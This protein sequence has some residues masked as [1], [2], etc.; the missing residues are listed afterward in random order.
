VELLQHRLK[1]GS[2]AEY[3]F[4]HRNG[5]QEKDLGGNLDRVVRAAC[6]KYF[7]NITMTMIYAHLS[8]DYLHNSVSVLDYGKRNVTQATFKDA[9]G[10]G[11]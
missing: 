1:Y 8:K 9:E 5:Q 7:T 2:W 10:E 6:Q 11:R 4:C 3:C